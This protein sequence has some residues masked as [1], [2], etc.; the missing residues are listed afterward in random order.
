MKPLFNRGQNGE[1]LLVLDAPVEHAKKG[2][3]VDLL[4]EEMRA[5]FILVHQRRNFHALRP[6]FLQKRNHFPLL[7]LPIKQSVGEFFVE[8]HPGV[9]VIHGGSGWAKE[10]RETMDSEL[11]RKVTPCREVYMKSSLPPCGAFRGRFLE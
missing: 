1:T 5:L 8:H 11:I 10:N 6:A 3:G 9:M 4:Q 7:I 2:K